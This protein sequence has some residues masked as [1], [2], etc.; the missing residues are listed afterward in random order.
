MV[1]FKCSVCLP[2][3]VAVLSSTFGCHPRHCTAG[4]SAGAAPVSSRWPWGDTWHP[5]RRRTPSPGCHLGLEAKWA[6]QMFGENFLILFGRYEKNDVFGCFWEI[7]YALEMLGKNALIVFGSFV[8]FD[9]IFREVERV[10]KSVH[11]AQKLFWMMT[12][13][14]SVLTLPHMFPKIQLCPANLHRFPPL[15]PLQ[16]HPWHWLKNFA[17]PR[18]HCLWREGTWVR[19]HG[20]PWQT[21]WSA[22]HGWKWCGSN[23]GHDVGWCVVVP[24]D[25]FSNSEC[26]DVTHRS[27]GAMKL[28]L[29]STESS[30]EDILRIHSWICSSSFVYIYIYT[31]VHHVCVHNTFSFICLHL[32]FRSYLGSQTWLQYNSVM[33]R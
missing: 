33:S 20:P 25:A 29:K 1:L 27:W 10:W 3:S 17:Q 11:Y 5:T 19:S 21:A 14:V 2:A 9:S 15:V 30:T 16:K 12:V 24:K 13:H 23:L 28:I 6:M 26:P 18:H 4:R 31:Y 22:S 8:L 32:S 7:W